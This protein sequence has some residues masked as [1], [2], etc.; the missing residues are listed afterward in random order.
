ML[1]SNTSNI[2]ELLVQLPELYDSRILLLSSILNEIVDLERKVFSTIFTEQG[3]VGAVANDLQR[4]FHNGELKS[5][6]PVFDEAPRDL[7]LN[8]KQRFEEKNRYKHNSNTAT[9]SGCH[10]FDF[11]APPDSINPEDSISNVA[12]Q[13]TESEITS[14]QPNFRP[15]PAV[16]PDLNLKQFGNIHSRQVSKTSTLP[17]FYDMLSKKSGSSGRSNRDS[18][19]S[20]TL[21]LKTSQPRKSID[22]E[23]SGPYG[24][25]SPPKDARRK[26]YS[27]ESEGSQGKTAA[28]LLAATSPR[29]M[30]KRM[31]IRKE[32]RS[33]SFVEAIQNLSLSSKLQNRAVKPVYSF[34]VGINFC[35]AFDFFNAYY[36]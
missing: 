9:D 34:S 30:R 22:S 36:F 17:S 26:I 16:N 33:D 14:R 23:K 12:P 29:L 24:F 21:R 6:L 32:D 13:M 4:R 1:S 35:A 31:T 8:W 10:T 11:P 27:R 3:R 19:D 25:P 18:F 2:T 15:S 28:E 7:L 5:K 20:P